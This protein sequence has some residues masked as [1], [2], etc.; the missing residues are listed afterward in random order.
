[1][2]IISDYLKKMATWLLPYTCI[3]CHQNSQCSRDLCFN[4]YQELPHLTLT[5]PRCAL[6]LKEVGPNILCGH[7][8][9]YNPPFIETYALFYYEPP[10]TRLILELKFN[11]NLAHARVLG[12]LLTEKIHTQWYCNQSLPKLIIPVPLHPKRIQERGFN[13]AIEIARPIARALQLP[14]DTQSC[15]RIRHTAAQATLSAS[16]RLQNIKNAFHVS[17][18]LNQQ[19]IA[20]VDDVITTGHTVMEFCNTLKKNGAGPISVWCCAR[21]EFSK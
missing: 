15:Q 16:E 19:S 12:E 13:Q 14:L 5:C 7:C 8:L 3:L 10:I 6:P 17:R 21:P 20:V 1:M 4:C 9:R 11:Q 18:N 2:K